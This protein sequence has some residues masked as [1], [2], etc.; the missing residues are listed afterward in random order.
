[1]NK[2]RKD[3]VKRRVLIIGVGGIGSFL[4]PLI[5]KVGS[6]DITIADPDKVESKNISYQNFSVADVGNT[7][8]SALKH[9]AN[10]TVA[11]P[12]LT[13]NQIRNYDL[14]VCC[15]DNLDVRRLIYRQGFQDN[16]KLKWLDL[17]AQGRNGALI[18]YL[19][20]PKYSDTF[21]SGPD[22]SFSCQGEDF[23][24]TRLTKR[25][26]FTHVAIAG[27]GAQWM[28]RWFNEEKVQDKV[29]INL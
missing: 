20:D 7:K 18:S 15:A 21:L 9:L 3:I 8:V 5:K 29:I 17:R 22:G 16:A 4:V 25:L 6:Y 28:Q 14:V 11:F 23:N 13:E 12:I 19:T 24:G 2:T 27:M 26:H 1:M 10:K